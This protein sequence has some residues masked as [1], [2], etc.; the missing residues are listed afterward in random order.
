M[1]KAGKE[2][3]DNVVASVPRTEDGLVDLERSKT[4]DN[5]AFSGLSQ[6]IQA[7]F[8]KL[9]ADNPK[10]NVKQA[11]DHKKI[12][13]KEAA[14]QTTLESKA[15]KSPTLGKKRDS[16][17]EVK[18]ASKSK[19]SLKTAEKSSATKDILKKEV[20]SLG[21]TAEDLAL[22]ADLDSDSELDHDRGQD[23]SSQET[24]FEKGLKKGIAEILKQ[25]DESGR[26]TTVESDEGT[27]D[28][29]EDG[30]GQEGE[31]QGQ[32]HGSFHAAE[33]TGNA[34][35]STSRLGRS[36]LL[37]E[38]RPDWFNTQLPPIKD[39]E[40]PKVKISASLI[41]Q[42]HDHAKSLLDAENES[43]NA[44]QQ[45]SSSQK[46]YSTVITSGTL[47]DKVSA[48]TLA[49][50]ES[51]LHN[52]RALT[53]LINLG[54]K[55]SRAQAVDVLRA[56]K[57]LFA[58]GSLLPGDR[59]LHAFLGH[60]NLLGA[61][62]NSRGWKVGDT[63]PGF[64]Q[65]QHLVLWAY[66]SWLKEKY[67]EVLKTLEIW[68]ND[69]I[70][71]SKSKAVNF[72]YELLREKPEQE[73]NL[74]R[75]LTNKLGDPSKKIASQTS[76]LLMQLM[77]AHPL[78]KMTI[79]SSIE[80]D[81]L[82]RPGQSLHAK[83]YAAITLNQTPLSSKEEEVAS[84]LLSTYFSV[85]VGLLKPADPDRRVQNDKSKAKTASNEKR[86]STRK[87]S[88]DTEYA[89]A[90]EL[91]E[92][93]TSAILTGI[94]RAYPYTDS[95][96]DSLSVHLETL[97]KITH[98]SNFNTSIQAM[99][100]IQQLCSSHQASADRFYR[101][102]YESLLDVRLI[103]SSKQSLYLNLLYKALKADTNVKRI[104]AFTKRIIQVLALHQ[105]SF[106]CG[107]FFLLQEL[108]QT[109]PG[110]SALIDQPEEHDLDE[111]AYKDVT[112]PQDKG[113]MPPESQKFPGKGKAYDG[114]KR[115][116]EHSSAESSCLWEVI[117][118]LAHFHPSVSVNAE[119]FIRHAKL[120][121]K[122]NL[123]LHT[124]THFL[125]RFAYRNAKI[126]SSNLRGSSIMQPLAGGDSAGL[127]VRSASH[128][129]LPVNSEKF[130][131]RNSMDVPA[132]DAFFHQ[133]FSSLGKTNS[134]RKTSKKMRQSGEND[135]ASDTEESE[136]WKAM[137]ES[138]P[139]LE[140]ADESDQGL[141]MDDLESD[142]E[143][144]SEEAAEDD[145][146][147]EEIEEQEVSSSSDEASV[148]SDAEISSEYEMAAPAA[149]HDNLAAVRF[150]G[151]IRG[152]SAQR[153]KLKHLP[154]FASVDDYADM[155]DNEGGEDLG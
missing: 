153:R 89:Q 53:T 65:P 59:K 135:D 14:P 8:T 144:S 112:E 48:L 39:S 146:D 140:G 25:I 68:C 128:E 88:N 49:V 97:F 60:P 6:K 22:V 143:R 36:N 131:N 1:A 125:D 130:W 147:D 23:K 55:R 106:I 122:P 87:H 4:L 40:V 110:L 92:K 67:F 27:E 99:M 83:Y 34:T 103:T 127:L 61:F 33:S 16:R 56:L 63:L 109:F 28:D 18:E 75:L 82:F 132:E 21:G 41:Q 123:E 37:I 115:D 54:K 117:P 62:A 52:T 44:T 31:K 72:V 107:C 121:G 96:S 104:K 58:Q 102:L 142:F 113:P 57:D 70:E 93:L 26:P 46:F 149:D 78:M 94:N 134:N 11:K 20:Y 108:R 51:P 136:I 10:V 105:P 155:I 69:E 43:F 129:Q 29:T 124:L 7:Q 141:E 86:K 17:G 138:A 19:S 101:T 45:S 150:A 91:R 98:S 13:R 42:V 50:Q 38:P 71:F 137:M 145:E 81:L 118:F 77:A 9:R 111:E 64:L 76:Y 151:K 24:E 90:D 148:S 100:L 74:L 154:T 35:A 15:I 126:G 85:F 3:G 95:T 133:Y 32:R 114:R 79:I 116:P 73:S 5:K 120:P 47:S 12:A 84:K 119:H 66:E 80:S 30:D 152:P 2:S 139:D